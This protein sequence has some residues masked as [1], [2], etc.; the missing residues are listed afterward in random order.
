M[1][2]GLQLFHPSLLIRSFFH[3]FTSF[4][5]Q[6]RPSPG[7]ALVC[8][9]GANPKYKFSTYTQ[10]LITFKKKETYK[11]A[12][13]ATKNLC[14]SFNWTL[15]AAWQLWCA[16]FSSRMSHKHDFKSSLSF[17]I[18]SIPYVLFFLSTCSVWRKRGL[19]IAH[20]TTNYSYLCGISCMW[21]LKIIIFFSP[22]KFF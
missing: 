3:G 20:K 15:H 13:S 1:H 21:R 16:S 8:S 19:S 6:F 18:L 2:V 10:A 5:I 14:S 4:S 17:A 7:V 12:A 9:P 11:C 22:S